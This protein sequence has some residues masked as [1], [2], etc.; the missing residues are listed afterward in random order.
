MISSKHPLRLIMSI[1]AVALFALLTT[2]MAQTIR[3]GAVA[4]ATGPASELGEPEVNTFRMLQDHFNEVGGIGGIPVE[5]IFLDDATDT[6]QAVTNVRRL[7]EEERV[8]A[9]ICCTTS[10]N[11]LAIIDAVQQAKVPNISMAASAAIIDPVEERHWVF[12]T[13]QTDRL[14]IH[15]IVLDMAERSLE[16]VGFI[17][18]DDAYGEGGLTELRTS[19]D[20]TNITI[21]GEE[22]YGR[23]DT[24]VTAQALK[25]VAGNPDAILVWG[26]VRDSAMVVSAL[27]TRN[28]QGQIY[29]SH[30]VGNPAFLELAGDDANGVRFPI[31]PM[32]V[33]DELEDDNPIKPV[34]AAY[35]AEYEA[36]FGAG[37]AST[38]GGHAA[39]AIEALRL[40]FENMIA[41]GVDV[42]DVEATRAA[43]RDELEAMPEFVGI[44]GVFDWTASDHLGLD[45]RALVIVEVVDGDWHLAQ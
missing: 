29:V 4:A 42:S 36:Q 5:I 10:P 14:M 1:L 8:H 19:I 13:P 38:F 22:R 39:D 3:I 17:G 7:I 27:R 32:I 9:V 23:S 30:G 16:S 28:Y 45:E 34:A 12:K 20:G 24:S 40:A 25:L 15:G 26:V 37:T 21:S 2:A 41:A 43:L 33:V 11:S 18:I 6:Q 31:G 35:V 44:G